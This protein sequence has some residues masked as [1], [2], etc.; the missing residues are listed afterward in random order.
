[1]EDYFDPSKEG[2]RIVTRMGPVNTN[3]IT[4]ERQRQEE[5]EARGGR[6]GE[7]TKDR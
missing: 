3:Q 6:D 7:K 4:E 5:N 2:R 1:M